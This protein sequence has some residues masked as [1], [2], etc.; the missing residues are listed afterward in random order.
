MP[1]PSTRKG[2]MKTATD[3]HWNERAASVKDDVEVNIMDVFQRELEYEHVCRHLQKHMVVLETGCGNGY[4]TQRFRDLVKHVDAFD[5]A[6]TMIARAKSSVG[7]TNN[8][9]ML[10]NVLRPRG[11]S[12]S[13]DAVL[14]IRV[15]IN[16]RDVDEQ[17]TALRNLMGFVKRGGL[18]ILVEGFREGFEALSELRGHMGLPPLEPAKINFYTRVSDLLPMIEEQFK[19]ESSFHLGA[20]DCLTRVHYPM[21]V[22]AKNARHNTVFSERSAQLAKV[23]DPA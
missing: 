5:Y 22:G 23:L 21:V 13:Y 15:L 8:R 20:Y 3:I 18:L 10:D 6:E 11:I 17:R 1:S 16:L 14:C 2:I 19:L 12:G 9:F 7:E 4:S